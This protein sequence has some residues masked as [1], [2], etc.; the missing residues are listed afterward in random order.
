MSGEGKLAISWLEVLLLALLVTG[1]M[2]IWSFVDAQVSARAPGQGP[3]DIFF[4]AESDV[5]AKQADLELVEARLQAVRS[6]LVAAES[7]AFAKST[8]LEVLSARYPQLPDPTIPGEIQSIPTSALMAYSE[9]GV[10]EAEARQAV[11]LLQTEVDTRI[12]E[13]AALNLDLQGVISGT[14]EYLI[15]QARLQVSQDRLDAARDAL[16]TES[17]TLHKAR[18]HRRALVE[19]YPDLDSLTAESA[20]PLSAEVWEKYEVLHSGVAESNSKASSLAARLDE[21]EAERS[22]AQSG[23]EAAQASF[24]LIRDLLTLGITALVI[25]IYLFLVAELAFKPDLVA[26]FE[27]KTDLVVGG[28]ALVL[29]VLVSYQTFG[30]L[31]AGLAATLMVGALLAT[32]ARRVGAPMKGGSA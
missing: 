13:T 22:T 8:E 21:L 6:D 5:P 18:A 11:E 9:S 32:L 12:A 3:L 27:I 26:R 25:A 16:V 29:L 4:Q 23:L 1:G 24:S 7:E 2:G 10:A 14:Q 30:L 19:V 31:G 17:V 28:A 15:S 20:L